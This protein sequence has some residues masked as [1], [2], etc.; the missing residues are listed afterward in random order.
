MHVISKNYSETF[1][2]LLRS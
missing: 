1:V 2:K